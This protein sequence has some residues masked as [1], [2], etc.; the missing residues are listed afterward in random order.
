[1]IK[2]NTQREAALYARV[3]DQRFTKV[4][5]RWR[6]GRKTGT[7]WQERAR[8]GRGREEVGVDPSKG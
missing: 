3:S 7:T 4:T 2:K 6:R 1:M 5:E 8:E